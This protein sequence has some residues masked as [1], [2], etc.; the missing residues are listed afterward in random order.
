LI[1]AK[2][3][4]LSEPINFIAFRVMELKRWA[5][6]N[7]RDAL[8]RHENM[9]HSDNVSAHSNRDYVRGKQSG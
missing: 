7:S 8:Q 6:K 5:K 2:D 3:T 9:D 4:T 1:E